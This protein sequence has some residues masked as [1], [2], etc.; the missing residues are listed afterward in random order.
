[1]SFVLLPYSCN[2]SYLNS[3]L[4]ISLVSM[5]SMTFA[6][7]T[8]F[9]IFATSVVF[10]TSV[11]FP[12]CYF[13]MLCYFYYFSIFAGSV[14]F[15]D[16]CNVLPFCYFCVSPL[17]VVCYLCNL[18]LCYFCSFPLLALVL[19]LLHISIFVCLLLFAIP[20]GPDASAVLS[21][22]LILLFFTIPLLFHCLLLLL[23]S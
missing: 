23:I 10:A 1:M 18:A 6:T 13:S 11:L 15:G 8:T 2:V 16:F 5:D 20:I 22:L 4:L 14:A 7:F 3:F 9:A 21:I 12:F 19:L 17:L